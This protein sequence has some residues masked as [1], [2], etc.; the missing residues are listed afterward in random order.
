MLKATV[1]NDLNDILTNF[2]AEKPRKK[3][4]GNYRIEED[5]LVYRAQIT[6][7][8]N[9]SQGPKS[10]EA[11]KSWAVD[12]E[13]LFPYYNDREISLEEAVKKL[14]KDEYLRLKGKGTETNI[15]AKKVIRDG[16]TIFLGNS[17]ILPLIGRTVSYG[18][19][20]RNGSETEIQRLMSGYYGFLMIPFSV[21]AQAKLDLNKF[22]LIEKG[23][24]EKL[25]VSKKENKWID[26]K[27]QDVKTEENRH[28]TGSS[29]FRVDGVSYLFDIDRVEIKHK[30]FNPFLAKLKTTPKTI[31]EAYQSLKPREVLEAEKKGLKVLRQGEWFFIETAAPKIK[32]LSEMEKMILMAGRNTW[33]TDEIAK[34]L[35]I[36]AKKLQEKSEKLLLS[37][38]RPQN[39]QAGN[40]RPNSVEM[41]FRE[42]K[43]VYCSG[44]VKHSGREHKDLVLKGW[45]L[46]V[47]NTSIENFTI[48]GNI[49]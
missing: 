19:E 3:V 6:E 36:D 5:Q 2:M 13:K 34:I 35:K 44:V 10:I 32:K 43:K 16:K 33:R 31:S 12:F 4:F 17:S 8:K 7:E 39:I 29:L 37:V 38:P 11:L 45:F 18:H 46:A 9:F 48:T 26:G 20:N 49:D 40:S 47:P 14:E 24:E 28:F 22:E 1:K 21:F 41:L 27:Y 15:V 25:V 42:G 30:I 23:P